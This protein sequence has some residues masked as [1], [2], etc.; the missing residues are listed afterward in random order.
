VR[1]KIKMKPSDFTEAFIPVQ[2]RPFRFKDPDPKRSW[3]WRE[4]LRPIYDNMYRKLVLKTSRQVEKSTTQAN[5][6]I[7]YSA[8]IPFFRSIY[9]TPTAKQ[10]RIFSNDRLRKSIRTSE[11]INKY[12]VDT[13]T[14]DQVFE[15]TLINESTIFI[16]YAFLTADTMRGLSAD[17]LG[18]DEFQ[19]VLSDNVPVL[20]EALTASDYKLLM[21]TGTPKTFDNHLE[22]EWQKSF[23]AVWVIKC[24][25]CNAYNRMDSEPEKLLGKN[26]IIC[27]KCGKP[28][29]TQNGMWIKMNP[30][31]EEAGFHISQL[32]TGRV[33]RSA[34]WKD[35]LS[36]V[37]G[38]PKHQVYNEVFGLSY[39]SSDKPISQSMI[40][41]A[42]T[43]PF[44]T[45][46]DTSVTKNNHVF[47]GVDW[48]ENKGSFNVCVVGGFVDSKRFQIYHFRKFAPNEKPDEILGE[49]V[50]LYRAF[51]CQVIGCDH[52]AGHKENLRLQ[53]LLG[54]EKVWEIFHANQGVSHK[55][56]QDRLMYITDRTRIMDNLIIPIQE[57]QVIFPEWKY[58]NKPFK[59]DNNRSFAD[60]FTS[61]TKEYSERSRKFLYDHNGP[62]D[63]FQATLYAK[64]VAHL[65][66]KRPFI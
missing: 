28:L 18:I 2:G 36:K 55:W 11:F 12:F 23:Q 19:D 65:F 31:S 1:Y 20:R 22:K 38:Y 54:F 52:G 30:S 53:E 64:F 60:D 42:A 25:G 59:F 39:D 21:Y 8:L 61:L 7:T 66:T 35:L 24:Q 40:Q 46:L 57:N 13:D 49:I 15:Q 29:R 10:A 3:N 14:T 47:M 16:G 51:R 43:G 17:M 26:G 6:Y 27:K 62:D 32:Q 58:T 4:Y 37:E 33:Q 5:R 44:L 45:A 63:G 48:G 9:V 41:A 50:R 56:D 34:D